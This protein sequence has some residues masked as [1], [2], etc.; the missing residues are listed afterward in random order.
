MPIRLIVADPQP[1]VRAGLFSFFADV[2]VQI[3]DEAQTAEQAIE[4]TL[5]VWPDALLLDVRFQDRSGFDVVATLRAERFDKRIVFFTSEERQPFLARALASGAD[6]YLL[7]STPRAELLRV[8]RNIAT[9][10][11][12]P[13]YEDYD[14]LV[15]APDRIEAFGANAG[16]LRRASAHLRRRAVDPLNPMTERETQVL[17]HIATGLSNKE[18]ASSLQLSLDTVKE[19]V[20]NILRKLDVSDR[21][22]AAVWAVRNKLVP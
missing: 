6:S 2:D 15:E 19:H 9:S 16:E 3:V 14:A 20:Q 12:S 22:Q 7:K 13:T 10:E 4:K 5:A 21:T 18:I 11:Y 17:R 8:V 1:V